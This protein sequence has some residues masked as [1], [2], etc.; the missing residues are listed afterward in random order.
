MNCMILLGSRGCQMKTC[1]HCE[2]M[3]YFVF[4]GTE[5]QKCKISCLK[6]AERLHDSL[7]SYR[8]HRY[9]LHRLEEL[10]CRFL[11]LFSFNL[12]Q[13]KNLHFRWFYISA[14]TWRCF[15]KL[16][17]AS[18]RLEEHRVCDC[19]LL[20]RTQMFHRG[21]HGSGNPLEAPAHH[22]PPWAA[23]PHCMGMTHPDVC[24]QSPTVL[25]LP[26]DHPEFYTTLSSPGEL[27]KG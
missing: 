19:V 14:D 6:T 4:P 7:C 23:S 22:S 26:W 3:K 17:A 24:S 5:G 8:P 10:R 16:R 11:L 21:T 25:W 12:K 1:V 20:L 9:P 15:P 2:H 13:H 18:P 27:M